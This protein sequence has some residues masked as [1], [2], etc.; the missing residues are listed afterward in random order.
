MDFQTL[1]EYEL[2]LAM[3]STACLLSY[4][5]LLADEGNLGAY[6]LMRINLDEFMKLD[7]SAVQA[8]N[9]MPGPK[10]GSNKTT[11]LFGILNKCKT[12]Q[13]ARLLAQWVKQPL[14]DISEIR[15][16][17]QLVSVFFSNSYLR[18]IVQETSLK[19]FPDLHRLSKKFSRGK[20]SLQDVIRIYQVVCSLPQLKDHLASCDDGESADLLNE[21]FV[22]KIADFYDRLSKLQELVETTVDLAASNHHEYKIKADF[23]PALLQMKTR[24]N[25]IVGEMRSEAKKVALDLDLE[26][27][28]KLKF[29]CNPQ[30]G[31]HLRVSRLDAGKL[32]DNQRYIVLKTVKAGPLFTTKTMRKLAEEQG[33][34]EKAYAKLQSGTVKEVIQ[35]TSTYM[36]VLEECNVCIAELDVFL[37]LATAA[38]KA[39]IP[40]VCPEMVQE[41]SLELKESRHPC[42]ELQDD[43][44]FIENDVQLSRDSF[45]SIIS[46]FFISQFAHF[47]THTFS[48]LFLIL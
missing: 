34:L 27:E 5:E 17:H 46:E 29:E 11:N 23:D 48:F 4:L 35:I 33:D 1:S 9:L 37:G 7:A 30:Y 44:A 24:I 41:G 15:L 18:E 14:M 28:K 25:E 40:Y 16:R 19:A 3:K 45:F 13:G 43:V 32:R 10:E 47:L 20:A 38:A 21:R 8:L 26:F 22:A 6:S 2:S 31:H 36:S 12:A 39:P 42:V